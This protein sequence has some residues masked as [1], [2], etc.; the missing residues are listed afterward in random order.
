MA[1]GPCLPSPAWSCVIS[2]DYSCRATTTTLV[3][4]PVLTACQGSGVQLPDAHGCAGQ[5]DEAEAHGRQD[6]RPQGPPPG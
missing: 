4:P 2:D 1:S 6:R 5:A 3:S